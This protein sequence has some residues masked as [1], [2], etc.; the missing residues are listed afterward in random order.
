MKAAAD[1]SAADHGHGAEK[2]HAHGN[3]QPANGPK[4]DLLLALHDEPVLAKRN[5]WPHEACFSA[6]ETD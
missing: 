3:P 5:D 4:F 2:V 6:D 1:D